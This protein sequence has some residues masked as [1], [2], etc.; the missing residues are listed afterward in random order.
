MS[1]QERMEGSFEVNGAAME[2]S[3]SLTIGMAVSVS[4][5]SMP[6]PIIA[7][8]PARPMPYFLLSAACSA[9]IAACTRP[10]MA[11]AAPIC[12][13]KPVSPRAARAAI[14]SCSHCCCIDVISAFLRASSCLYL[15][16]AS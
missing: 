7:A 15:T 6:S 4:I 5:A 8:C 12:A 3:P 1:T 14:S 16:L 13:A 9:R 10:Y 2:A 11:L